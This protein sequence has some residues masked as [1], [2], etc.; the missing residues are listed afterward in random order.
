MRGEPAV[1]AGQ[2]KM[3]AY[4]QGKVY[5]PYL[6]KSVLSVDL[7]QLVIVSIRLPY[8]KGGL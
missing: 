7:F 4:W 2:I 1:L 8:G 5:F 6:L 3:I